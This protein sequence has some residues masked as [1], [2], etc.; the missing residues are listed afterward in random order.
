VLTLGRSRMVKGLLGG[1]GA[2]EEEC[3][4]RLVEGIEQL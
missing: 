4:D 3:L 2:D 1:A